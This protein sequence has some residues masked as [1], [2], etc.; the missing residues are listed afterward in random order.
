L[1][2]DINTSVARAVV[3]AHDTATGVY[4][5]EGHGSSV[6]MARVKQEYH[7]RKWDWEQDAARI[8]AQLEVYSGIPSSVV[9]GKHTRM[10]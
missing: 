4:G 2:S 8:S 3:S 10:P 5:I 7:K 1:V 9:N 6:N